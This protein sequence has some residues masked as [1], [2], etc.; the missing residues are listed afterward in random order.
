MEFDP[1]TASRELFLRNIRVLQERLET[2]RNTVKDT[3][4][5][6]VWWQQGLTLFGGEPD[7]PSVD[8]DEVEPSTL[9]Q[10]ILA[11]MFQNSPNRVWRPAEVISGLRE[12]DW[13]PDAKSA[14]QMVRNRLAAMVEKGEL[15][16]HEPGGYYQLA[17]DIRNT[18][19]HPMTVHTR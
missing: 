7:N 9:R 1:H 12:R 16:R 13:L 10:A 14:S 6:L 11:L 2:E 19:L 3:E 15:V 5:E 8:Q 17:A 18:G 4:R